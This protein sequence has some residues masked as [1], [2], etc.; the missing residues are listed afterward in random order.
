MTAVKRVLRI[1]YVLAVH[2]L[3]SRYLL[4]A[5]YPEREFQKF[6]EVKLVALRCRQLHV[7]DSG[8]PPH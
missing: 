4:H 8:L 5:L 1:V 6:P 2:L 7:S 3:T